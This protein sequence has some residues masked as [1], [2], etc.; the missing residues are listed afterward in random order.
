M[1]K[2]GFLYIGMGKKYRMEAEMSAR[3]VKQYTKY[4][5]CLVTEDADYKS[6]FFDIIIVSEFVPDF[7]GKIVCMQ[8]SPFENTFYLDGDTF[9]CSDIDHMFQALEVFDMSLSPDRFYHDYGFIE[10]YNPSYKIKYENAIVQWHCGIILYRMNDATRKFFADW[11]RIH[12][13][14]KMKSDMLSFRD[15]YIENARS[16]I[17]C[18]LPFEYNYHG[19][20]AYGVANM[21]IKIIHERLGER[22]NTLTTVM[23][24]FE[25]MQKKAKQFNKVHTRRIIIP[26]LGVLP[27]K[28]NL[29]QLKKKIKKMLGVKRTKKAETF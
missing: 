24:P 1:E 19:T 15:A 20:H 29:Y 13:E 27:Y 10:K 9:V 12:L 3:S 11:E 18:P 26:Y 4:K 5:T 8:K 14:Q 23:L 21:E 17:I 2:N 7:Y 25:K 6:E 16:V 22:W 28:W